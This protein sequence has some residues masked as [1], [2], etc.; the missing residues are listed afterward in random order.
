MNAN[1]FRSAI[2]VAAVCGMYLATA[3]L[4]PALV[5]LYY[6]DNHWRVFAVSAFLI[7]GFSLLT[8]TATRGAPLSF[9]KRFGF[10]LVNV[11]WVVF[12][13]AGALPIYFSSLGISVGQALFESVSAVTATGATALSGLDHMPKGL[14]LWRSLLHWL[15]GIG[16][17]ALGLFILPFLRV[18]G[19]SFFKMESSDSVSDRPFARIATFIR[20]FIAIYT[21]I[22]IVCAIAFDFAGMTRFDAINHALGVV[23]TGGFSTHDASFAYW[24]ENWTL[25]WIATFFM[26]IGSLP[27][28]LMILFAVRRRLETLY[29]PQIL[30]FFG[31]VSVFSV[32]VAIY[33]HFHSG[34]SF[35]KALTHSFFNFTSIFSTSGY[36]SQDYSQWGPFVVMAAFVAT[37]MGG[38]SGSTAGGIKAYRFVILFKMIHIGLKR[39]IYPD[40]VYSLR[41]GRIAVDADAQKTVVIFFS[42]FMLIW[43]LGAM[44]MGALGYD[45]ITCVSASATMIANVGMGLGPV[46]GPAGNFSSMNEPAFFLL[47][48]LMLLGR[49]EVLSVLVLFLPTFWRN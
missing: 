17:V 8:A 2:H 34:V 42:T 36:A 21:G 43:A 40:A 7:G 11:L 1:L 39:L 4:I 18:G 12:S 47:S 25:L 13:I 22:T 23:S 10:I 46:I 33:H 19:M 5:D 26:I 15:G 20:A 30:V 32:L 37:F 44:G 49:L 35:G 48:G 27:F 3:M 16:I 38:C 28:S 29:D 14:L 41:Y 45:L 31:Y 6:H 24:G 9:N